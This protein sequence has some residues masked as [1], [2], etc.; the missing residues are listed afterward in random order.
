MYST[1]LHHAVLLSSPVRDLS[2]SNH[3]HCLKGRHPSGLFPA[4]SPILHDAELSLCLP[5]AQFLPH[6]CRCRTPYGGSNA[7]YWVA[8]L[9]ALGVEKAMGSCRCKRVHTEDRL[10][11]K[12]AGNWQSHGS[13]REWNKKCREERLMEVAGWRRRWV[14]PFPVTSRP[15]S[16]H[17]LLPFS[18]FIWDWGRSSQYRHD[19]FKGG[20]EKVEIV[21]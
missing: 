18:C 19:G 10:R 13:W 1:T 11:R 7:V 16:S 20:W 5:C 17:Q 8:H 3:D 21:S 6:C 14:W 2:Y 9:V 15:G 4:S 12:G